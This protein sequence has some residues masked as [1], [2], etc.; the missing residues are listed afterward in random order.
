[1]DT[2][3][4]TRDQIIQVGVEILG[5]KGFNACGIDAVLKTAQVPKGSFY[6]YFPSKEE[7]GLAVLD[8]FSKVG[9]AY[10]EG[11]LL[12]RTRSPLER[13]R[14]FFAAEAQ[15]IESEGCRTGCMLGNLSQEMAGQH[16]RFRE[17]LE[18]IWSGWQQLVAN[19]LNEAKDHG[20]IAREADTSKLAEFVV[21]GLEGAIIRAKLMQSA[22]PVR[23]FA[24]ILMDKVLT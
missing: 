9:R 16:E 8:Q 7:F 5:E 14:W 21:V 6:Y 10:V 13:L 24:D 15:R 23:E 3:N 12:D 4:K 11:F 18:Q 22:R 19:C 17:R 1:M 20:E 2:R